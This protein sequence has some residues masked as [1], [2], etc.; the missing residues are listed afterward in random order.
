V[1]W[2]KILYDGA[3]IPLPWLAGALSLDVLRPLGA[4]LIPSIV[5]DYLFKAGSIT[6]ENDGD[7]STVV[8]DRETADE[9]FLQMFRS[10]SGMYFW[11]WAAWVA[12]RAAAPF[13]RYNGR[14]GGFNNVFISVVL[15]LLTLFWFL[16]LLYPVAFVVLFALLP[17]LTLLEMALWW[18]SRPYQSS[19]SAE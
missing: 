16:W 12:V 17:G 6:V 8:V 1:G 10:V 19:D 13:V 7:F 2:W 4:V 15:A 5:H 9:L 3:S 11:P 14:R 18:V